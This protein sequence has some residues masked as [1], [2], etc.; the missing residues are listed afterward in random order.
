MFN[1]WYGTTPFAGGNTTGVE[2]G[3][4]GLDLGNPADYNFDIST[5][6]DEDLFD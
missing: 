4:P 3:L 2:S 5:E 1:P 6:Y